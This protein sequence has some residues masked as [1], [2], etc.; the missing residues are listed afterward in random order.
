LKAYKN[1]RENEALLKQ[2]LKTKSLYNEKLAG[3]D[4]VGVFW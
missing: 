4:F 2:I 1:A 3:P